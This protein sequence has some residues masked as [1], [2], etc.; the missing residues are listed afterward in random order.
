VHWQDGALPLDSRM[1]RLTLA[2][3]ALLSVPTQAATPAASA[4]QPVTLPQTERRLLHSRHTGRDYQIFLSRPTQPAP[5]GGCPVLYVLD[6]N[7]LFP[8]WRCRPRRW[9][10]AP[11]R[12][13]RNSVLVVGVGYPGAAL[14]DFKA[15]AGVRTRR[16]PRTA[17]ACPGAKPRRPAAPSVSWTFWKANSSR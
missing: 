1:K 10:R 11:S 7:A 5:P 17:S 6:G 2:T 14:Y 3:L 4:W 12:R 15:R 16:T 13:S 9:K 8:R